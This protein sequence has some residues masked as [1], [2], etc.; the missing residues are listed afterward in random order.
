ME[1]IIRQWEN[2]DRVPRLLLHS[3]CGPCSTACME[4]L[5]E[6]FEVTVFYYNPNIYPE[7]EYEHR[8]KEQERLI[9]SFPHKHPLH[10]LAGK[11]HPEEFYSYVKGWEKE[12][13]GGER[14]RR[15]FELRLRAACEEAVRG[16]F[17]Y[18][19][20]T[21]SIS[22]LK[23]SEDLNRI[24]EVIAAGL[25]ERS[26]R[27]LVSDFK[28]KN[29]YARSVELSAEYDMYRQDYC[30]CVYSLRRDFVPAGKQKS[31]SQENI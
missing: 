1:Q 3:C 4:R 19:T 20:T 10:F 26:T 30:G 6:H 5:T 11:Y 27:Y 31:A 24:G 14:C 25:P 9:E 15:C 28:K 8:V 21:L 2:A 12:P 7:A 13:E 16:G 29:G 18:F 22:P 23:N 17:D